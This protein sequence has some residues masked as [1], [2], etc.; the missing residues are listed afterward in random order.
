MTVRCSLDLH[1]ENRIALIRVKEVTHGVVDNRGTRSVHECHNTAHGSGAL[2]KVACTFDVD[3][4]EEFQIVSVCCQRSR[5]D[6]SL[7]PDLV[8]NGLNIAFGGYVASMVGDVE[9]SIAVNANIQDGYFG[10]CIGIKPL[11]QLLSDQ[12]IHNH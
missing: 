7:R 10:D 9:E 2:K 1:V 8:K 5:V 11:E 4:H 12:E 3:L 6:D